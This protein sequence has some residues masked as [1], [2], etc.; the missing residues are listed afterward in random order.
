MEPA[1]RILV[2]EEDAYVREAL[3]DALRHAGL[4][5]DVAVD[6]LDGLER[7][8]AGPTPAL[9]LL[10]EALA[11]LRGEDLL[12]TMRGDEAY[13]HV[14]V[15][16]MSALPERPFGADPDVVAHINKPFDPQDLLQIV[17]SLVSATAA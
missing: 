6:G 15:I 1:K 8:R 2:V 17:L 16:T 10:D 4:H 11:K 7:L 12:R 3:A 14:P 9:V 13:E 5:V